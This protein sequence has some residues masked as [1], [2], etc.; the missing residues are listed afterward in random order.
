MT[1]KGIFFVASGVAELRD[2]EM[3]DISDKPNYIIVKTM[4]SSVSAGTERANLLGDPSNS[5]GT[6]KFP[7]QL[8]YSLSGVV[9]QVG[10][11]VTRVKVGDRV[12]CRWTTHSLYCAMDEELATVIPDNVS[13]EEASLTNIATFPMAAIRKCR[14]ELAESAIVMGLGVLGIFAI[15][16]LMLAGAAPIIAVDPIA[17]KR[18]LALRLGA[19]YAFDPFEE[20]FAQ[21]VKEI[22]G[23]GAKVA[24]EVTGKGQGLDMVLDCMA[25]FGRVALL[26]C[27]RNSDFTIDYYRKV[28][29][30]GITMV[31]A[32]TSA[33]PDI[34]SHD[35]WWTQADD[36]KATLRLIS[37]GRFNVKELIEETH[38]PEECAEVYARLAKSPTFPIVQF[39]WTRLEG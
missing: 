18:E 33:R 23:G 5:A 32:H 15:K 20:G 34:E 31:G 30:P 22:T 9:V 37:L 36:M 10:E 12:A 11:K 4:N 6:R 8:G 21:K 26:G 13:F 29:I 7:C 19:D 17:E 39:D 24:I 28:H 27:T 3:P 2:K 14:L 38:L 25:K 1:N 35:G 16:E